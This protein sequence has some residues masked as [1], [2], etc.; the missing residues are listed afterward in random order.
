MFL[1]EDKHG[2]APHQ[3]HISLSL[4]DI[5]FFIIPT[6]IP[7]HSTH[8]AVKSKAVDYTKRYKLKLIWSFW[9]VKLALN[10]ADI[11]SEMFFLHFWALN[12]FLES[13]EPGSVESSYTN[14]PRIW[15]K[16]SGFC[17]SYC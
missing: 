2:E 1:A 5:Y 15:L 4:T 13:E 7:N 8:K 17:L 6:F 10:I 11:V 12:K 9:K 14:Y 3:N 16:K